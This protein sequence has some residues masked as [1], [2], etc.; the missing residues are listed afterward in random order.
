[1]PQNDWNK[2]A[3]LIITLISIELHLFHFADKLTIPICENAVK[4][5]VFWQLAIYTQV[6]ILPCTVLYF[7]LMSPTGD[8]DG[9][10]QDCQ[11]AVGKRGRPQQ[12]GQI[13]DS[14]CARC[15]PDGVPG[16]AAG[17]GGVRCFSKHPGQERRPAYPHCH[18]GRPPGRGGV[19]GTA[20]RPEACQHQRSDGDRRG[21]R[22]MRAWYD[23]LAFCSYS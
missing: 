14:T 1:M 12:A 4:V 7:P 16:H 6:L 5:S 13:R 8:D 9:K 18:P 21:A 2:S 15:S 19:L 3:S 11:V 10:L 23:W 20:V 22:V 17:T